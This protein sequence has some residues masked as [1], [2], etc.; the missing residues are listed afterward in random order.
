[1][2][3]RSF[4]LHV[5][6]LPFCSGAAAAPPAAVGFA[7]VSIPY[8][9]ASWS[10]D[11]ERCRPPISDHGTPLLSFRSRLFL[12][13]DRSLARAFAGARIGM[14][15]VAA[16][17][18]VSPVAKSAVGTDFDETLDVHRNFLAQ[19]ALDHSFRLDDRA[20]TID[21]FLAQL[22]D[23]FHGVH[24]GLVENMYG[25]RLADAVDIR[26]RDIDVILARKIDA[27]DTCH[28]FS[29]TPRPASSPD[30]AF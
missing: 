14:R 22:L 30:P 25:S 15:A 3:L 8:S 28:T 23:L 4:L 13:R 26:Q 9:V 16:N 18:Q 19:I 7:I 2:F 21:L 24:F 20:D 6:F 12:L 10:V 1:M 17:R 11:G 5:F 27:S 29:L